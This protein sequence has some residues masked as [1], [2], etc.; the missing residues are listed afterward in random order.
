MNK[1]FRSVAAALLALAAASAVAQEMRIGLQEDPD[2]LDPHRGR[3]FVGRIVLASLCDKL[4]D[5]D[6]QLHIVPQLA[7][8]WSWSADNTVLTMKLR[9]DVLFHD[10][11]KFDAAAAKANLDRE[12]TIKESYRKGEVISIDKVEAPDPQTLVIRLK[13]PDATLLTQLGD[14]AGMMMSPASF[15]PQDEEKVG[16]KPI[17]SGPFKFVE[18]VQNDRVVLERFD[19][20][21]DA[22][23]YHFKRVVYLP[24]PDTTVRLQNLRAGSLD[25]LERLSPSDAADVQKDSH[26]RFANIAGLGFQELYF[27]IN[28]GDRAK[29]NPFVDPR[30]RK[31]LDLAIDRDAIN[32]VVGGGIFE[33][34]SQPFPPASPYH[35]AK[36]PVEKRDVAKAKALL[37]E[38]GKTSVKAELLFG[39]NTTAAAMAEMIQA[40]ARE[41]GIELS[42]RPTDYAAMLHQMRAGNF[43]VGMRNWSGRSDPDGNVFAFISCKGQVNDGE[44]C[45]PEVDKLLHDARQTTDEAKR[46]DMYEQIQ[47]ITHKD[48]VDIFLYYPPSPFAL[49]RKVQGF[50]PHPDGLIHLKGVSFAQQ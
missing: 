7:T 3:T 9:T 12:R 30:V 2:V 16:R 5:I 21:Y 27:N 31:A 42:L 6:P 13:Y 40:M 34:A 33:P 18:R 23:D 17:C 8:S 46:K 32:Q 49:Q 41:A 20:Y 43:E 45:N 36:F 47:A 37:K 38:A 39:N 35:S 10:E 29:T 11:T 19:K 14:R 48:V 25:M 50:V 15:D 44:Y 22:K 24:I 1:L 4:V 26:L 28:N